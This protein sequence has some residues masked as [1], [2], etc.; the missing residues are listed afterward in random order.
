MRLQ[1]LIRTAAV[2]GSGAALMLATGVTASAQGTATTPASSASTVAE[3]QEF[4]SLLQLLAQL[5]QFQNL[6][7]GEIRAEIAAAVQAQQQAE[8]AETAAGAAADAQQEAAEAAA[9]AQKEAAEKTAE[10][11]DTDTD[12]DETENDRDHEDAAEHQAAAV[13]PA[14][15]QTVK[16]VTPPREE[17]RESSA[18]D[19]HERSGHHDR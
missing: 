16:A 4:D 18:A 1:K 9:E 12:T 8:A 7:L 19:G 5:P 14:V 11:A 2:A 13:K 10:A 15:V 17:S 3:L 6:N